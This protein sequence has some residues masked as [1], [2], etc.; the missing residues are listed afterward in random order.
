MKCIHQTWRK[1][2]EENLNAD[3]EH[4][5]QITVGEHC[6]GQIFP[7]KVRGISQVN[8][9]LFTTCLTNKSIL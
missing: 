7:K 4:A 6:Y 8:D 2:V 9:T 1:G 3:S 5:K